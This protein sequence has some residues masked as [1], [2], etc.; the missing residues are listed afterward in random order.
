MVNEAFQGVYI[1]RMREKNSKSN[2]VLVVVLIL[3]SK[4]FYLVRSQS[5]EIQVNPQNS[6]K[7]CKMFQNSREILSNTCQYNIFETHL[8]YGG[9]LIAV[10][11]QIYLETSSPQ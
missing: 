7:K 10:N 6:Q 8:G 3:E 4:G 1:L 2:L 9:C 11:L 5:Q